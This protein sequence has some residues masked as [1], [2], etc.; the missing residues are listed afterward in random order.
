MRKQTSLVDIIT[1]KGD[2]ELD[3]MKVRDLRAGGAFVWNMFKAVE[4]NG[5]LLLMIW[6]VV[7]GW[8]QKRSVHP[9]LRR[10][11]GKATII[12]NLGTCVFR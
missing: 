3:G 10:H 11:V 5:W 9:I 12:E 7:V 4:E 1:G 6:T 8:D 2:T